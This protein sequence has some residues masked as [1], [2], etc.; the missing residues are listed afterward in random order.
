MLLTKLFHYVLTVSSQF[1]IDESHGLSHSMNTLYYANKIFHSEV[2]IKPYIQ[3]QE[4]VIYVS[5]VLHDMCDK[6]YVNKHQQLAHIEDFLGES[7]SSHEIHAIS[8]IISTMPYSYVKEHGFPDLCEYQDAYHIVREADLLTAYD[9]D[10]SLLYHIHRK[11]SNESYPFNQFPG[12]D[13]KASPCFSSL[14]L[15]EAYLNVEDFF[16][17][18]AFKHHDDGLFT[19]KYAKEMTPLLQKA[20]YERLLFWKTIIDNENG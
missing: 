14:D 19:T 17:T 13:N 15:T 10:R 12:Y 18:R 8:R 11:T 9:V 20:S 3:P 1:R 6:K 4:R 16:T 2:Q 7:L 5:A